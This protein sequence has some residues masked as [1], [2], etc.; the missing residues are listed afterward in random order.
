MRT[1]YSTF[2]VCL[3]LTTSAFSQSCGTAGN[4]EFQA[5]TDEGWAAPPHGMLVKLEKQQC[6]I[7]ALWVPAEIVKDP[8]HNN[9][10]FGATWSVAGNKVEDA[11]ANYPVK[12]KVLTVTKAVC[13]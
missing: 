5:K 7:D 11:P 2:V 9:C 10:K 4:I 13:K 8:A 6:G 12:G 3:L 1:F